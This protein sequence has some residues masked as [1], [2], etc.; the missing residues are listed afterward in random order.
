VR[1]GDE[2]GSEI[3]D[4]ALFLRFFRLVGGLRAARHG[5]APK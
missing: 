4:G 3:V 5:R 1:V 2:F